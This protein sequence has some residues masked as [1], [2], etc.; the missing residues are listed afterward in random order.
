VPNDVSIAGGTYKFG[1]N[2]EQ[3]DGLEKETPNVVI[4]TGANAC[5]KVGY[6]FSPFFHSISEPLGCVECVPEAGEPSVVMDH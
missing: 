1:V 5:G 4:C 3:G 2:D 6:V